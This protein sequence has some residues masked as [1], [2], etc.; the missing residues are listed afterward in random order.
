MELTECI[1]SYDTKGVL[2]LL[3]TATRQHLIQALDIVSPPIIIYSLLQVV[4]L[5]ES[6][7]FDKVWSTQKYDPGRLLDDLNNDLILRV[8][9]HYVLASFTPVEWMKIG[10]SGCEYSQKSL[11]KIKLFSP[12]TFEY[13]ST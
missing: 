2:E 13:L 8:T 1:F 6:V 11:D 3:S 4:Q 7:L 5:K 12:S 9:P 10:D